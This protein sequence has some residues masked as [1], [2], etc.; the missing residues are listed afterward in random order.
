MYA[1]DD[2]TSLNMISH[3]INDA[4][5]YANFAVKFLVGNKNDLDKD[6]WDVHDE[7]AEKYF[8]ESNFQDRYCISAKTGE[9]IKEMFES[10][11]R[12]LINKNIA[13]SKPNNESFHI[14]STEDSLDL[15]HKT[16][17]GSGCLC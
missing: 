5:R 8:K 6:D 3:W 1:V 15:R 14:I 13:P 2:I 16:D 11:S 10:I 9:G 12:H 17:S 7:V 4:N